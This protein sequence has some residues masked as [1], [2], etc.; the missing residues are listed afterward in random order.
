MPKI[1]RSD[2]L[3]TIVDVVEVFPLGVA[4]STLLDRP[5]LQ[6]PKRTLQ[7]RLDQLVREGRLAIG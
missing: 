6:I 1:A 2:S 4:V 5:E 7:R 3:D